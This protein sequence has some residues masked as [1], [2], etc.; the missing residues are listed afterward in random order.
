MPGAGVWVSLLASVATLVA[1]L[2]IVFHDG[3][4]SNGPHPIGYAL[5]LFGVLV[6]GAALQ[7]LPGTLTEDEG[8]QEAWQ[9]IA[10]QL[11]STPV[12]GIRAWTDASEEAVAEIVPARSPL[13]EP[14][15]VEIT[16]TCPTGTREASGTQNG[17]RSWWCELEGERGGL[18]HGPSRSWFPNGYV[19]AEGEFDHGRR[20]GTWT[21]YW[22]SGGRHVQA[23]FHDDVQHGWMHR[24]DAFG[25]FET[26][27]RYEEG[28]PSSL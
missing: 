19:E 16:T 17:G 14:E 28:E 23:E 3:K 18:R 10:A 11:E 1:F 9:E 21:R 15:P 7:A 27:V 22:R 12:A 25:E 24:W 4:P 2:K 5:T 8:F 6:T 13:E 20:T 26:A